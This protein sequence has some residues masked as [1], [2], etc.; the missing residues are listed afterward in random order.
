MQR[1]Q[2]RAN[3]RFIHRLGPHH[4]AHLRAVAE[5]I[6]LNES[7]LRYLGIEHGN[8]AI[9]AHR[10]TVDQV[11]AIARRRGDSAWRLIGVRIRVQ[12]FSLRPSLEDFI[13]DRDL[14]G[15]SESEQLEFYEAAFPTDHKAERRDRLRRRQLELLRSLET[16]NA[17]QPKPQDMVTGW[18]DERSATKLV[19]AGF[20]NLGEMAKAIAAGGRWYRNLPGVG[21]GKAQRIAAHLHTLIPSATPPLRR[22]F[23]L[24]SSAL[25]DHPLELEWLPRNAYQESLQTPP[26]ELPLSG[27]GSMLNAS[28]DLQAMRTWI[29]THAG[30]AATVKSFWREARVFMLWLQW[31]RG[32]ITFSEVKVEDCLA[33]RA[34]TENIPA[35]WISR[36]RASPGQPGWAPFRGQLSQ[37][38]RHHLLNI[39]GALFA[40]LKL[41]DY[42][43][44]N[45]WPLI[46]TR[47]SM[48]KTAVN[49]VDTRAFSEDAQTEIQRFID[50]QP[51]S[52]SRA[53]MRFIVGFLSGVGLRASELLAA[54]L[55][56]LRYVSGGYV[57]QVIGKGGTPRVVAIPPSALVALE[58]YLE[59][60]GIGSLQ[61]A[62]VKAP[63]L[64]SAKGPMESIG[65]QALYLTVRTWLR[66]AINASLL[67]SAE[68]QSLAGASAHWLRHTFATRAIKREVPMEVVQ[69]QLGHANISTTMNIY[70][71]APLERQIE[72]ISAAFK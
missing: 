24:P 71:K 52:P 64:A 63:L 37:S 23:A 61:Q 3:V 1:R 11:R 5:G 4:F 56:D 58:D 41:A 50:A 13:V 29:Q 16:S 57:L 54:R 65:Y 31:E 10:Q 33:F 45:P 39:V 17:E 55:G 28:S 48:K 12:D 46:K 26:M 47:A 35:H 21:K 19:G 36:E 14:D 53:R 18:F 40:Y 7:A 25:A 68:R 67:P 66:N 32:G 59:A 72:T 15:W 42:I 30:S 44:Q 62:P 43:G 27:S 9:T 34:F 38:S 2:T 49:S 6:D 8:E 60:R 20:I 51:P 69:A 22:L 70:A